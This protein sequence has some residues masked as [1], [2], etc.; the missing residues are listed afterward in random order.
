MV[1]TLF[2]NVVVVPCKEAEKANL[3]NR[4]PSGPRADVR[5]ILP[6]LHAPMLQR[7]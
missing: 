6:F 1:I 7:A 4:L 3:S 5:M 2:G